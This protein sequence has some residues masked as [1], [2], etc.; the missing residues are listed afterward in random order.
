MALRQ[1]WVPNTGV[2]GVQ[3][4]CAAAAAVPIIPLSPPDQYLKG[5]IIENV[6]DTPIG[7]GSAAVVFAMAGCILPAAA[8]NEFRCRTSYIEVEQGFQLYAIA[9]A[10]AAKNLGVLCFY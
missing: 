10:G 6:S 4:A 8:P 9:A 1:D 7:L 3:I 2:Q 5:I